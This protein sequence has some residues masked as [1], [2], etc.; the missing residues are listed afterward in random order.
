MERE[1][2]KISP[3]VLIIPAALG[4]LGLLGLYFLTKAAPPTPPEEVPPEDIIYTVSSWIV[5]E[6]ERGRVYRWGSAWSVV[7][8]WIEADG[9]HRLQVVGETPLGV[10]PKHH[11]FEVGTH[12]YDSHVAMFSYMDDG[13]PEGYKSSGWWFDMISYCVYHPE[14][15]GLCSYS[16]YTWSP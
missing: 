16:P 14:A 13:Y 12:Y 15:P 4:G 11:I 3:A 5:Y 10:W 7:E 8:Y 6:D 9:V 2:R 1:E